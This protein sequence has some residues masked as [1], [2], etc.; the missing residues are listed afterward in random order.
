MRIRT[1]MIT[2]VGLSLFCLGC[3]EKP[4]ETP[5]PGAADVETPAVEIEGGE[6]VTPGGDAEDEVD[7]QQ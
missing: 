3:G 7:E 1:W 2:L 5:P 4:A 6:V